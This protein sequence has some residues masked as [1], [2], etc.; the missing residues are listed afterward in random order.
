MKQFLE[1]LL[2]MVNDFNYTVQITRDFHEPK[3]LFY[4]KNNNEFLDS[5][6]F[7]VTDQMIQESST[8]ALEA[9]FVSEM[10]RIWEEGAK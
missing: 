4:F 9:F 3:T 5:Q 8:V 7:Q 10:K 6:V 2:T 1:Q